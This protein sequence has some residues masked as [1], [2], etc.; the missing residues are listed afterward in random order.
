[1]HEN[2]VALDDA[3]AERLVHLQFAQWAEVPVTPLVTTATTSYIYRVGGAHTAR[4]PMQLAD[5]E[6]VRA[7]LER[8]RAAMDAF[9]DASPVPAPRQ[10]AVG[11][12][13]FGYSMPWSVQTWID[14]IVATPS[15]SSD[16][17]AEDLADLIARLREVPTHGERFAGGGRGG[18]IASHD[19]WV[20]YCLDESVGMLP[21]DRLRRAWTTLRSARGASPDVM[22]H[23]D[24]IPANLL[25]AEGRLAGVLDT[26]GFGP[27]DPALD[28]VSG[29]HVLD[30][31][32]RSILRDRLAVDDDEWRRGAA[33]ALQQAL[34]L[35]WYYVE[36]NPVM[37][38]LGRSTI[39]RLLAAPE[40]DL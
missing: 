2:Q 35:V 20:G 12:P 30:A 24:L 18:V 39:E 22:S 7:E 27:A 14:G 38:A 28:L 13:A 6:I 33:W 3:L 11:E 36:T 31:G 34:G 40:L 8:E 21:V 26:G 4:F 25:V 29:W 23:K 19:E 1:M 17:L 9:A 32:P 37:S 15:S 5:A 10:V 16:A